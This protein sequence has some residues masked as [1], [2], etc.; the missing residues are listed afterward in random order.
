MTIVEYWPLI[1]VLLMLA[2]VGYWLWAQRQTPKKLTQHQ[3]SLTP[4]QALARSQVLTILNLGGTIRVRADD[5]KFIIIRSTDVYFYF[6]FKN[7]HRE[8]QTAELAL[9]AAEELLEHNVI[10]EAKKPK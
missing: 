1:V 9:S 10:Y 4:E 7:K 3:Q 5:G 2:P 8:F 6:N